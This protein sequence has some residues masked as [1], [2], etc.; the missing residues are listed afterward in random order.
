MKCRAGSGGS[1]R[2]D[3]VEPLDASYAGVCFPLW[4]ELRMISRTLLF[5]SHLPVTLTLSPSRTIFALASSQV[6]VEANADITARD[7]FGDKA[8]AKAC[9]YRLGDHKKINEY[10][11]QPPT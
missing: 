7:H 10:L 3:D 1:D 2:R 9:G 6:L 11:S 4:L 5:L 8:S